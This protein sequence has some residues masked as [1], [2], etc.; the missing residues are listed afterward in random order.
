MFVDNEYVRTL[1]YYDTVDPIKYLLRQYGIIDSYI[2]NPRTNARAV[3]K[4]LYGVLKLLNGI[5]FTFKY[6]KHVPLGRMGFAFSPQYWIDICNQNGLSCQIVSSRYY[7]YRYHV[8][9]RK[10]PR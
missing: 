4:N 10:P 9:I 3:A 5:L 6:D 8:L 7:E 1:C 2:D